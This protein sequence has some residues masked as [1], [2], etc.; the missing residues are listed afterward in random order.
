MM[1]LAGGAEDWTTGAEAIQFQRCRFC[2]A[3]WYFRRSFCPMCG[4]GAP[5]PRKAS[6]WGIVHSTTIVCRAPSREL[7]AVAPYL[8]CLVDAEERFRLMAH[9][10]ND[11]VIG[12]IVHAGFR[13]FGSGI[14]PF[15]EKKVVQ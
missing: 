11:L 12:D 1:Q 3:T 9:G 6:G 7:Q 14:V 2:D 15:F 8:L 4:D 10:A 5:E 13:F